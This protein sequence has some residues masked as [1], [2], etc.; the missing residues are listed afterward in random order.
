MRLYSYCFDDAVWH[1]R[2]HD[3]CQSEA[4]SF[5]QRAVLGFRAFI[6]VQKEQ[7][8]KIEEFP[9]RRRVAIRYHHLDDK[10]LAILG[11]RP[12]AILQDGQGA[13]VVPVM[14]NMLHDISIAA[15]WNRGEEVSSNDFATFGKATLFDRI[16]SAFNNK[17]RL[18]K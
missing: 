16:S 10:E 15:R 1:S 8:L 2:R 3:F 12:M 6:A 11:H 5:K 13:F 7:H 9:E 14:N 4:R 18:K 17:W